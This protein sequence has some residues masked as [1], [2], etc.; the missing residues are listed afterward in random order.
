MSQWSETLKF[1]WG[2][3]AILRRMQIES[4]LALNLHAQYFGVSHDQQTLPYTSQD[5]FLSLEASFACGCGEADGRDGG[6]GWGSEGQGQK[7][8]IN[9][10]KRRCVRAARTAAPALHPGWGGLHRSSVCVCMACILER[11]SL[12]HHHDHKRHLQFP[13]VP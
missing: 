13:H 6:L 10:T 3:H 8:E 12:R 11:S 2:F 9:P 1:S 4:A 7:A 5:A